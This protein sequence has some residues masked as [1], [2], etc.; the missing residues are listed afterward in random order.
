MNVPTEPI[1][2]DRQS[3]LDRVRV[4]LGRTQT[5]TITEAVPPVDQFLMRLASAKDDLVA[6]FASRAA[7]VGM[8]V[9]KVLSDTLARD[10]VCLLREMAA[11]KVAI[12]S[13]DRLARFGIDTALGVAGFQVVPWQEQP[14]F[15]V[16]YDLDVG[17]T[18]VHA[19]LAETGTLVCSS[20][21][22][23]SRG[24]S[25]VPPCH[26]AVLRGSDILPDMIDYFESIEGTANTDLPSSQV[27]ITGPSKTADIEGM[28]VT[29]VHGPA[30]VYILLVTDA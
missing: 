9:R 24:L 16:Q 29:G 6:M 8:V 20:D 15:E 27:F 3:F 22:Q 13:A 14:G 25:L 2:E 10:L 26:V 4:A 12:G 7:E 19:A 21:A 18:A 11:E 23:S 17:I 30:S 5:T 28:L 1:G